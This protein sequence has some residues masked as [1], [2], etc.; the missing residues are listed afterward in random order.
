[1]VSMAVGWLDASEVATS[2]GFKTV[3]SDEGLEE[4][5]EEKCLTLWVCRKPKVCGATSVCQSDEVSRFHVYQLPVNSSLALKPTFGC[6]LIY[7]ILC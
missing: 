6:P 5:L 3:A 7:V 2:G 4:L 1:M